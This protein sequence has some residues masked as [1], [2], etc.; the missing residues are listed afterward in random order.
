[1]K[2]II[3]DSFMLKNKTAKKLYEKVKDLPIID[4]HCHLS[5][6]MIAEN[7][8]F[9]NVGELFLGGDHYKWRQMRTHGIEE[10][11][12][13]GDADDYEKFLAFARASAS[14]S[15]TRAATPSFARSSAVP[16][17]LP[18]TVM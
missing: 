11:Y 5:P 10:K 13:T 9:R 15:A 12:I 1:M 16:S 6:K 2:G 8:K 17:L 7:Y 3:N 4:Y 18:A 14:F